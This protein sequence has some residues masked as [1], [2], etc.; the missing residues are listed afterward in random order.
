[1]NPPVGGGRPLFCFCYYSKA[2]TLIYLSI[3]LALAPEKISAYYR[4]SGLTSRNASASKSSPSKSKSARLSP[5]FYPSPPSFASSFFRLVL[6]ANPLNS[7][8]IFV[9][10]LYFFVPLSASR[11][12]FYTL[13]LFL[14][15]HKWPLRVACSL[16]IV[17]NLLCI[18]FKS[19]F[20]RTRLVTI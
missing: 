14:T 9:A 17:T 4:F 11:L 6:K 2:S 20:H 12:I 18:L 13:S 8:Y 7:A 15:R 5:S 3:K 19:A 1:M 16:T 10:A